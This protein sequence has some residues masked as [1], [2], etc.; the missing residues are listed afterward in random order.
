M[1][2]LRRRQIKWQNVIATIFTEQNPCVIPPKKWKNALA[3]VI[4]TNAHF[5]QPRDA[6]TVICC[7][8][9]SVAV[10]LSW[11]QNRISQTAQIGYRDAKTLLVVADLQK[12]TRTKARQ[13]HFGT[14]GHKMFIPEFICGIL[15]TIV[16]EILLL[17]GYAIFRKK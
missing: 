7:P 9:L 8:A 15:A 13:S 4:A 12:S 6:K 16:V 10:V 2:I 11:Y 17:I 3:V 14:G 1:N 5:I